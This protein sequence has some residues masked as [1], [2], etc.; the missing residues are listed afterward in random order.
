MGDGYYQTTAWAV[1]RIQASSHGAGGEEGPEFRP[2]AA[3]ITDT[4]GEEITSVCTAG[5][6]NPTSLSGGKYHSAQIFMKREK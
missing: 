3:G 4:V 5:R 6:A 2:A 1:T